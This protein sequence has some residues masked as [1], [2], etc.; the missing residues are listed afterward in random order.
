M[1][2]GTYVNSTN[3]NYLEKTF[4]WG[5]LLD[6]KRLQDLVET[7]LMLESQTAYLAAQRGSAED[8]EEINQTILGMRESL[9]R[10]DEFLEFDLRFHLLIARATQN[11]IL[12]SMLTTTRG[13]LQEWIRRN[14]DQAAPDEEAGRAASSLREHNLVLEAL[15]GRRDKEARA[16]MSQ[17]VLASSVD[18][19]MALD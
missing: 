18:L 3:T 12:Y 5:L 15:M 16:A 1:G 8:F 10:P 17:H 9:S 7:R 2:E 6:P 11:T 4:K 13:Y 19:R 14:L